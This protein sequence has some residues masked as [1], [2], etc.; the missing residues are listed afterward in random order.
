MVVHGSFQRAYSIFQRPT[1]RPNAVWRRTSV[2]VVFRTAKIE[3]LTQKLP[4]PSHCKD[5]GPW[6]DALRVTLG[7]IVIRWVLTLEV[8]EDSN[9]TMHS[10]NRIPQAVYVHG[11]DLRGEADFQWIRVQTSGAWTRQDDGTI[12]KI[13]FL[14]LRDSCP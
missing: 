5:V 3:K 4:N 6:C 10:L 12:K 11:L 14:E 13:E 9:K 2:L 1:K 8:C 7:L